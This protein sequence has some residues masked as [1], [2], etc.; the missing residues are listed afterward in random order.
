MLDLSCRKSALCLVVGTLVLLA[1]GVARAQGWLADRERAEGPGFRVGNLEL[2]PGV[3][4]EAGYDS[5]VFLEEENTSSSAILRTT[6]HL[7]LSTLGQERREEG[8]AERDEEQPRGGK[9]AFRGGLN[10]SHYHFFATPVRDNVGGDLS[11]DLA[12]N[13]NGP[14]TVRI[15][16]T[17][18]RTVRPFTDRAGD[19]RLKWGR[20]FN[21]AGID[22][23]LGSKSGVLRGNLGYAIDLDFF[24]EQTFRYANSL[25]HR[26]NAGADWKFLPS[27]ALL[28]RLN[29]RYRDYFDF[30]A[31]DSPS[32]LSDTLRVDT[33]IGVNGAITNTFSVAA[34]I[35]YSAGFYENE[36]LPNYEA[37]N[38]RV[39]LRWRP[40]Q[41]V[42]TSLGYQRDFR[43]SFVGN[44]VQR[45]RIY[46][47]AQI[48]MLGALLLAPEASVTFAETDAALSTEPGEPFLGNRRFRESIRMRLQLFGEYRVT[49]WLALNATVAYSADFTDYEFTEDVVMGGV[50]PDPGAAWRKFEVF[51]GV[52]I[53][54]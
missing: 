5:N 40:R 21:R 27:T 38:G 43:A 50:L 32:L 36:N 26:V 23:A 6:A 3:G 24:D 17:L 42:R 37:P 41:T 44:T 48:T 2:H 11:L 35:G 46:A 33:E 49:N 31:S 15:Y 13:P 34:L 4:V 12:I 1:P 22:F 19:A 9:V 25:T 30:S 39:E 52:R 28:Y 8:E 53:F 29:I 16:D 54:Y 20:N 47:Q 45:N 51:G 18:G 7:M 14:F 10:F